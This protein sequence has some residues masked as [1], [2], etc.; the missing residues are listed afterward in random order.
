MTSLQV[1]PSHGVGVEQLR[2]LGDEEIAH[3]LLEAGEDRSEIGDQRASHDG[4][5]RACPSCTAYMG[6]RF[7]APSNS[8]Q[9]TAW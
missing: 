7:H 1:I 6:L 2:P 8:G 5:Q 3:E 4:R 9:S